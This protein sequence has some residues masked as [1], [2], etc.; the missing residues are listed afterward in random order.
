MNQPEKIKTEQAKIE[1]EIAQE[2]HK[3]QRLRNCKQYYEKDERTK[4]AHRRIT[5]GAAIES[6]A[7]GGQNHGRAELL[8]AHGNSAEPSRHHGAYPGC[9]F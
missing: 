1:Q 3:L 6:I 8:C 9:C 4:R 5:C 2:Q 7:P